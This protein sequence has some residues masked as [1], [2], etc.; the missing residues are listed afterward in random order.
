MSKSH[1]SALNKLTTHI[2]INSMG[3]Y[4]P[5]WKEAKDFCQDNGI[6]FRAFATKA[7][8]AE[9]K[10]MKRIQEIYKEEQKP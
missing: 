8:E 3:E 5:I 10:K 2:V 1:G 7:I 9:L 6:V 4:F